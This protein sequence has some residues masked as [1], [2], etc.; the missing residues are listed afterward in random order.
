MIDSY[1]LQNFYQAVERSKLN[2]RSAVQVFRPFNRDE[3]PE[4]LLFRIAIL[5]RP[6]CLCVPTAAVSF[7]PSPAAFIADCWHKVLEIF[8]V[9]QAAVIQNV[10]ANLA[11]EDF[12]CG[13]WFY[14]EDRI[15]I[16]DNVF[17]RVRV[18]ESESFGQVQFIAVL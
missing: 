8:F 16:S 9:L 1:A 5:L 4:T 10:V 15:C 17:E 13:K 7:A 6:L 12:L 3:N 14:E 2:K 11:P 18:G